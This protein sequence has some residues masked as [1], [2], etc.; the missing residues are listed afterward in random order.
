MKTKT[1]KNTTVKV[2]WSIHE[3]R[4]LTVHGKIADLHTK[5]MTV[6]QVGRRKERAMHNTLGA[7]LNHVGI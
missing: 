3:C 1:S 4:K 5:Y 6:K 2:T 7:A